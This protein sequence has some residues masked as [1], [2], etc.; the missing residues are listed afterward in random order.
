MPEHDI[1]AK[2]PKHKTTMLVEILVAL[3]LPLT[4]N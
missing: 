4:D 3:S 1:A 2:T